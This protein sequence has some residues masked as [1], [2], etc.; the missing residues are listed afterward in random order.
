MLHCVI[1]SLKAEPQNL[2]KIVS[3]IQD[4]VIPRISKQK[5]LKVGYYVTKP[6]GEMWMF[7]VW[8]REEQFKAWQANPDHTAARGEIAKLR[9]GSLLVDGYQ[10]QAYAV[11]EN[12]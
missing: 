12:V 6:T 11:I 4:R 8:E 3:I 9:S 5:G 2:D 10:L 7:Q 1:Q